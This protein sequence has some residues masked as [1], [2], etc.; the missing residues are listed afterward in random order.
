MNFL[1]VVVVLWAVLLSFAPTATSKSNYYPIAKPNCVDHCGNVSIPFPFGLT[2]YCSLNSYFFIT[3]NTSYYPPQPFL[4]KSNIP[5]KRISVEGQLTIMKLIAQTCEEDD[6]STWSKI[7]LS[8]FFVNQ[9]ANKFVAVG[10]NTIATISGQENRKSYQTGCISSCNRFEDVVDGAC[11]GIGCCQTTDIPMLTS[12]VKFTLENM[13]T[14]NNQYT[15]GNITHCSYAFVVKK[16]EF[17]FS[18][19][20]LTQQWEVRRMPMVIDWVIFND[21]CRNSS[22]TCQGNT[23]CVPFEGPDGGYRCAC[24]KGYE[25]NPYL[26]PG[27][28][29]IDECA[30]DGQNDCSS[31]NAIC[32]NTLGG[33]NCTCKEGYIDDGKGTGGCQ[34][35]IKD[36]CKVN[37]KGCHS[38][39][40]VVVDFIV[41]GVS[42]GMIVLLIA[43]FSLYL[44]HRRRKSAQMKEKFFRENG[45]LILQ[46]RISQG[47]ASSGTTRIFTAKELE[48]A[49]N[50]YDQTKIIGQGGFGI[51]YKGHLLDGRVVAVK[52]SK[53]M[54]PNQVEQF[55]N[56][57]IVLSQINHKN[58]VKLF[59]CCLE[60]EVPLLVYEFISNGTLSEHIH[61]KDKASALPWSSRLRIATETAEVLSYL[62]SAASP[63]II[64]RDVKSVNIL[65]DN[66]YIAKVSD[67]GASRLVPQDQ[68]QLTTM[69]QGTF[70]YLD[71]EYMQTH[72]LTEKS[73][74]YS[75]GVVLVEL[76]TSKGAISFDGP[77]LERNLSQHF[78]SSL[79]E[80]KLF[81]ILDGN[82]LCEGST[83]EELQEVA[84][85]AKRCL[86]FKGEDRPTMKEVAMELSGLR[87]AIKHPW[88]N[89]SANSMESQALVR[90]SSIPLG[91]DP[92]FSVST[93]GYDSIK[94]DME[95]PLS[96]G[97]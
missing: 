23:I 68:T 75:F 55:I 87:R 92:N 30:D 93:I 63:P 59:G 34:L 79:K 48:K 41:V 20:M 62:H 52:R 17:H 76:L 12:N 78:L 22:S 37:G 94:D 61:N 32:L 16:D 47:S 33:Y 21:T 80:N 54:D 84:L 85:L 60:T 8:K 51:V 19:D 3:C 45:G 18:S 72:H 57:V 28:L 43:G 6:Q 83:T 50:N 86:N 96:A 38:S 58:I 29:D 95:L 2:K 14:T 44:A 89:N 25:G 53:I 7:T 42:L 82:I 10:C 11:N 74:V 97:R 35:P 13:T 91:Y 9:T 77:E 4:W 26:H 70:G 69:V 31:K 67:F 64:H 46:Q 66:D 40:R 56:E 65:L 24:G 27:C 39:N 88:A 81:K 49:T 71:P 5:V 90:E 73:D 1:V 36:E 15:D